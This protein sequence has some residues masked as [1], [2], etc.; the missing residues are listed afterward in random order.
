[1]FLKKSTA[2]RGPQGTRLGLFLFLI[3][4]NAA[5]YSQLEQHMGQIITGK[6]NKR[7]PVPNIHMKNVDDLSLAQSLNLK[8]C[9]IPN[10]DP[11]SSR[12]MEGSNPRNQG[13]GTQPFRAECRFLGASSQ[14]PPL[15][16]YYIPIEKYC[17]I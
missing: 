10:P 4:I 17:I 1:M 13:T 14:N 7:S 16:Y 12:L 11:N 15:I 3:L 6:L 8:E 2:R 5:G 9:L